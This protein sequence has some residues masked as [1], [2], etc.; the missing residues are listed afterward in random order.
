M[1]A[2]A[3]QITSSSIVYSTVH[4]G[5]YQRKHQTSTSLDFVRGIHRSPVNSPHKGPVTRKMF[6]FDDVIM[7]S[8]LCLSSIIWSDDNIQDVQRDLPRSRDTS[9]FTVSVACLQRHTIP[10]TPVY[11]SLGW[12]HP[13]YFA[14]CETQACRCSSCNWLGFL[15]N[16]KV[17]Y[18]L[19]MSLTATI[20]GWTKLTI[21]FRRHFEMYFT[22]MK[23]NVIFFKLQ[24]SLFRI[25]VNIIAWHQKGD[26]SQPDP[27]LTKHSGDIWSQ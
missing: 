10:M 23:I 19:Q 14:N 9:R 8:K 24:W 26:K 6:P 13:E 18:I 3:S 12:R 15:W 16:T 21:S 27:M 1:I 4:S 20:D 2:M 11:P 17:K 25:G 5:A 22:E 7:L